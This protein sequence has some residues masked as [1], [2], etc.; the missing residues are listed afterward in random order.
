MRKAAPIFVVYLSLLTL[1]IS[2]GIHYAYGSPLV[3]TDKPNYGYWETVTI[4]GSGFNPNTNIGLTITRPDMVVDTRSTMSDSSGN[5]GYYYLLDGIL[6]TYT[7]VASDG[8]HPATTTF[9]EAN[10]VPELNGYSLEPPLG[11]VHGDVKGYYECQWVPFKIEMTTSGPSGSAQLKVVVHQDYFDGSYYGLD[12]D[13]N[14]AMW[15]NGNPESPTIAGPQADGTVSGVQQLEFNWTVTV[16]QGDNCTLYWE[17]HVAIGA[18]NYPGSKVH[19]TIYNIIAPPGTPITQGHRDVPVACKG[20][21][22]ANPTTT[23]TLLSDNSIGLGGSVTD[24][25]T[26]STS[27]G[28]TLPDAS[29]TWALYAADNSLMTS[30]TQIDT[31]SVS[32]ALPFTVTSAAWTPTYAGDWYFQAVYSGDSNYLAS[33]SDPTTE[34]LVVVAGPATPSVS[35]SL[36]ETSITL[37]Q[38]VT[39]TVTVT[40]SGSGPTGTADFQVSTDNGVTW[41]KFGVTKTLAGGVATSDSYTPMAAGTY[42]FR[43]VYS[44]DSNYAGETSTNEEKL[45]VD[46]ATPGVITELSTSSITLGHSITDKVTVTGLGNGF[47]APTG[48]ADF[49]VSTNNGVT[50]AK[51]GATKNLVSGSATSDS[52]TPMAAGTYYFRAVYS[53][54]SNYASKTSTNEEKLTVSVAPPPPSPP[55]GGEWVPINRSALLVPWISLASLMTIVTVS[56]VY[57][58]RKKRQQG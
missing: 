17:T 31:G 56:F 4:S 19:T 5:F 12:A 39:D 16:N 46:P 14:F 40:G 22:P 45:T 49:Q 13:Q 52:Y 18:H 34:H 20:A 10:F 58:E 36:S 41:M 54:D 25:I 3:W 29:G 28:G 38:S 51:F 15:R 33:Q 44:G 48:T 27:A 26:I 57:V 37:G 6:G 7:V 53:G 23:A 11:W 21:Q 35:T 47:P 9:T 1:S 2:L 50:W 32:G 55:V 42:Y 43:A 8:V 24:T 30:A